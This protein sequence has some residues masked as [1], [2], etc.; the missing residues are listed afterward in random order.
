MLLEGESAN[1]YTRNVGGRL[2][3]GIA[4]LYLSGP[5]AVL[6]NLLTGQTQ[7]FMSYG[8]K[9][10]M[11]GWYNY[12]AD[13]KQYNALTNEVGAISKNVDELA[14]VFEGKV[15]RAASLISAPFRV[16]ER[17]NRHSS[18]AITDVA[19]RDSFESIV[20][21]K[22]SA[23][24]NGATEARKGL[25]L[26]SGMDDKDIEYMLSTLRKRKG[27][28][29]K[30]FDLALE[31]DRKFKDIWKRGLYKSQGATQGVTQLPYLPTWTAKKYQK[32]LTLFYR[33]A[34]RVTENTFNNAIKP[35]VL[36]G[37]PFPLMRYGAGATISGTILF[38]WYY[39]HALGKDLIGKNFKEVPIQ[40]F[41]YGTRG[42]MLGIFS[43]LATS[44]KGDIV[45]SHIP[46]PVQFGLE[47]VNTAK[48]ISELRDPK[49]M[50]KAA[51]DFARRN[52]TVWKQAHDFY[53]EQNADINKKFEDQ[54]RLQNK[55]YNEYPQFNNSRQEAIF[56]DALK[57]GEINDKPFY[58][59]LLSES[60][61]TG[62]KEQFESDFI[63]TRAFLEHQ[64]INN[65]LKTRKN[66][67]VR[68]VR[69]EVHEAIKA[70]IN[71]R[72]RPYPKK[73]EEQERGQV[74]VERYREM[75]TPEQNK[76]VDELLELYEDRVRMLN[77]VIRDNYWDYSPVSGQDIK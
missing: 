61:I 63:K 72:L 44:E 16:I 60:L 57:R 55:F 23:F 6:K 59:K 7:N 67:Y 34:Y 30:A 37:N 76:D 68:E 12:L 17:L 77:D 49:L 14:F 75:L 1:W 41:E 4:N 18:V 39:G 21:N 54:R 53:R 42:E 58:F 45:G 38:D 22:S 40:Y 70:S 73:W 31:S 32:P 33:T 51:I 9:K 26:M 2:T 35:F 10:F 3:T 62:D 15:G 5:S 48:G 47:M 25:K 29:D 74:F 19:I 13:S 36:D 52:V 11:K 65:K 56:A 50:K 24:F 20:K 43:N 69:N 8:T 71:L 64:S 28:G 27:Y 46:V 66:Y